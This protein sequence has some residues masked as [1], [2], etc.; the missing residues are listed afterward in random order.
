MLLIVPLMQCLTP[1]QAE[2]KEKTD[3]HWLTLQRNF[4]GKKGSY[5]SLKAVCQSLTPTY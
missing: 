4:V 1:T 3:C 5:G 2:R